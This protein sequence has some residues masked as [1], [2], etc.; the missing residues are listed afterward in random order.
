MMNVTITK[1]FG[2]GKANIQAKAM[3]TEIITKALVEAFGEENVA[4]IRTGGTSQ[5][6][7]IGVRMGTITDADGFSYDFCATVNP[8][9]KGFKER[10]TKRYTVEAFDFDSARQAYI[11]DTTAKAEE[12]EAKAEAKAKKTAKDK[13]EREAKRLANAKEKE[14]E[15][16]E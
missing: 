14:G 4:M 5:V 9:I 12:K 7:E 1:D 8:T 10:V 13:T 15:S 2:T 11:D 6:N 16:A 3:L